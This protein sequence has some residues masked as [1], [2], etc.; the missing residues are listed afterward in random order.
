[1]SYLKSNI[2]PLFI[3]HITQPKSYTNP[4]IAISGFISTK[5]LSKSFSKSELFALEYKN[6]LN[7][8]IGDFVHTAIHGDAC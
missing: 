4:N 2:F 5:M 7:S 1:M 6:N 8:G 3:S